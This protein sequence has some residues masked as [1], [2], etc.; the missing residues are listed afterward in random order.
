M[1][2]AVTAP[3]GGGRFRGGV[4]WIAGL[5][6]AAVV[7]APLA[8]EPHSVARQWNELQLQAI[9]KDYAFP[10]IHARNLYHVSV[11]MWDAWAAYDDH[12]QP[13][14][15]DERAAADDVAAARHDH[16]LPAAGD[17]RVVYGDHRLENLLALLF[18]LLPVE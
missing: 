10:T 13:V 17:H 9:R 6:L 15:A 11:A 1:P 12:A 3:R 5:L 16:A 18:Y 4:H 14:L 2:R 7:A 8:A